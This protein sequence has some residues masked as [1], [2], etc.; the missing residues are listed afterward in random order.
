MFAR[1]VIGVKKSTKLDVIREAKIMSELFSI[2]KTENL[3]IILIFRY[4]TL[5]SIKG[6]YFINIKLGAFTFEDYIQSYFGNA[7]L[8]IN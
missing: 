8:N 4:S 2:S 3:Y 6:Y 7:D 1:K 5:P